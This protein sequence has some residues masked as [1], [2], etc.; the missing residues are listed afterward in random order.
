MNKLV[1]NILKIIP[2]SPGVYKMKD[3]EGRVLYVGKAKNLKNRVRSYFQKSKHHSVR[4]RKMVSQIEDIEYIVV[5]SELEALILETNLIKELRPKYNILMKDDKNFVYIKVTTNEDFPRISI[6]RQ[7]KKD[8]AKYFGPKTSAQRTSNTL[9][10]LKKIFPYRHCNIDIKYLENVKTDP[11]KLTFK[12]RVSCSNITIKIPCLDY[13]IKRCIAPCIGIPTPEG[14]KEIID[15][16][17]SFLEGKT[18]EVLQRLQK[19]M[20]KAALEKKFE[21]AA[22]IRD[23]ILTVESIIERQ[24][25]S[26]PNQS[27][28]DIINFTTKDS[29]AFFNVFLIRDGKLINQETFILDLPEEDTNDHDEDTASNDTEILQTFLQQYY[30]KAADI[31][32]EILIPQEIPE[33]ETLQEF[34]SQLRGNKVTIHIPQKGKKNK[35]LELCLKNAKIHA[36]R[37]KTSWE[38]DSNALKE[39]LQE[40]QKQLQLPKP[41]KRIEC[42]DISHFAGKN[43]VASMVV[44]ENGK[45]KNKDYR[46]FKI[47]SIPT[48]KSD[49]YASLA[50]ALTRRLKY[51]IK[52]PKL[53]E[54][55]S[56]TRMKKN[57]IKP[58]QEFLHELSPTENNYKEFFILKNSDK[59]IGIT[60]IAS[61]KKDEDSEEIIEEIQT[62]IIAQEFE[63]DSLK[64]VIVQTLLHKTK[65]KRIYL[66]TTPELEENFTQNGFRL[67]HKIPSQIKKQTDC[68]YMVFDKNQQLDHSFKQKPD[69]ILIDGGKGQLSTISNVLTKLDL[70]QLGLASIAKREEEIFTRELKSPIPLNKSSQA[71]KILQKARDEAHRFANAYREKLQSRDLTQSALDQ[72]PG[73]GPKTRTKLLKTFGS[74]SGIKSASLE[75]ISSITGPKLAAEIIKYLE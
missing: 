7:I 68:I 75:E 17:V 40:L 28:T 69:L 72:I 3:G 57:E 60:K 33:Q 12:K 63:D 65:T 43:T 46:Q 21:L 2:K 16:V 26:D 25:I 8:G 36:D 29:K 58:T 6:V 24:K 38:K 4:T 47:R 13:H 44:L 62:P 52:K 39:S 66:T 49:D 27:N 32:K 51:L 9:K 56:L 74:I 73:L 70:E 35:L 50:E 53:P 30:E 67:I 20:Q 59:I 23:T 64:E 34:L 61:H 19:K 11:N 22:R 37:T 18:D 54:D 71:Q 45:P 10:A 42:Y 5:D 15:Q 55:F 31:G 41:P 14:Y 1:E 48:G